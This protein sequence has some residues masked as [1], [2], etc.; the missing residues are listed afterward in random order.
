[1][2]R[3]FQSSWMWSK[4]IFKHMKRDLEGHNIAVEACGEPLEALRGAV[5]RSGH[6]VH[7]QFRLSGTDCTLNRS[8]MARLRSQESP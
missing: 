2:N 7:Q 5:A 8:R 4:S 6:G 3:M 1:M